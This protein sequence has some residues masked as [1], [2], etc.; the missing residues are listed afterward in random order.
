MRK[1]KGIIINGE[2]LGENVVVNGMFRTLSSMAPFV[3]FEFVK[4]INQIDK[5]EE[6][7]AIKKFDFLDNNS[8]EIEFTN[9]Q[10]D[11][12]ADLYFKLHN[13]MPELLN[14]SLRFADFTTTQTKEE[15]EVY[16]AVNIEEDVKEH[17]SKENT[18]E[19]AQEEA[20]LDNN[21]EIINDATD[22]SEK[23]EEIQTQEEQISENEE[24]TEDVI[25]DLYEENLPMHDAEKTENE[26]KKAD[27]LLETKNAISM[28]VNDLAKNAQNLPPVQILLVYL[29]LLST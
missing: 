23:I 26:N 22:I 17:I 2:W 3:M 19:N 13:G 7:V 18:Q 10:I 9:S 29:I 20:S 11:G 24:A 16:E 6:A 25:S 4:L 28:L 1:L 5:L 21:E 15:V 27:E 12:I 14:K 8:I